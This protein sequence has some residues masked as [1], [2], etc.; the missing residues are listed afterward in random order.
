MVMQPRPLQPLT[1]ILTVL[2]VLQLLSEPLAVAA[3]Y[4]LLGPLER[5]PHASVGPYSLI[6]LAFADGRADAWRALPLMIGV[7]VGIV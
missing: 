5:M 3:I 4:T 1:R 6:K 7:A 2:L